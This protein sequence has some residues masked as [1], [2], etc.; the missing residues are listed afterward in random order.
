[1]RHWGFF[2]SNFWI[3]AWW[4]DALLG[5]LTQKDDP[6]RLE[7]AKNAALGSEA[8]VFAAGL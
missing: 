6:A 2:A 7:I 5:E 8:V 4:R 1:L 3:F